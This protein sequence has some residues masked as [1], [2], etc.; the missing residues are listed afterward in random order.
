MGGF[1]YLL[2]LIA[3][4]AI[5]AAAALSLQQGLALAQRDKELELLYIG[6]QFRQALMSYAA[7]TPPGAQARPRSLEQL[8]KDDRGP[9]V[10]RHLRRVF[11]DPLSGSTSWG[12]VQ[13]GIGG[14]TGVY[15]LA[16]GVPVKQDN[17]EPP[18]ESFRIAKSYA[19]WVFSTVP[20]P[21]G[22]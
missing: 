12:F 7:L 15:S 6:G 9:V 17:F 18:F 5:S 22:N 10:R 2:V 21:R 11:V 19:D 3:I 8:V 13:D 4:A 1:T 20:M 14:I 16:P